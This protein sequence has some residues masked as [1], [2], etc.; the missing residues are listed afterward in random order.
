[1]L[2]STHAWHTY[3]LTCI[4]QYTQVCAAC[5]LSCSLSLY[6][7]YPHVDTANTRP[8]AAASACVQS[9]FMHTM[10]AMLTLPYRAGNPPPSADIERVL[11]A[12]FAA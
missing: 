11:R 6:L 1:M 7:E 10:H 3:T 2:T 5:K 9:A 12:A 4:A 8:R